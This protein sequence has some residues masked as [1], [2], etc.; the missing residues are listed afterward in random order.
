MKGAAIILAAGRGTRMKSRL[1]KVLHPLAGVPMLS[2]V[3]TLVRS[4]QFEHSLLIVGHQADSVSAL[5]KEMGLMPLLQD[6]PLGTGDAVRKAEEVLRGFQGPVLILNGDTPLL[7]EETIRHFYAC[8]QEEKAT[9]GLLTVR[10]E[11]PKGYGRVVRKQSGEIS[12]IV[13]EKDATPEERLINEVNTGVYLCDAAFLFEALSKVRSDNKQNEYYLTDIIGIAVSQGEHL[14]GVEASCEEVIGVNSRANLAAVEELMRKRINR[15]WMDEGV[16]MIDPSR[17]RIGAAVEIGADTVLYPGV[18][19]EGETVIGS[20]VQIY[21]GR[22][23]DSKVGDNVIIKDH[24]VIENAGVES[25]ATIGP[26]AHLRPGS[27]VR[28]EA[29]VGNFVEMKKAELGEGSKASHLS[30]LGD[31]TIGRGVNIGAGTI[32][33]NYDGLK[34]GQTIIKD[35]V[36]IGSDTQLVAP[37]T[38]GEGALIAAGTTV[39]KD[40]PSDALALSRTKQ[41]NRLEWAKKRRARQQKGVN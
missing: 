17:V 7:R 23:R 3:I 30:Y 25:G 12:R 26:F 32:T 11:Y 38:V 9:V 13:E 36:F 15:R 21:A 14:V 28:K 39:T 31:A 35:G 33:C 16:T 10:L 8:Y 37:V 4:L 1:A 20:G 22:I 27:L 6:P 24:C 19:L 29:K 5:A 2:H 34:K 18:S 40:V 41:E